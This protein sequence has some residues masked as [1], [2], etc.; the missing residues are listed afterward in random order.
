M[1]AAVKKREA[2]LHT[3][4]NILFYAYAENPQ[5]PIVMTNQAKMRR[6]QSE[7]IFYSFNKITYTVHYI[8]KATKRNAY[9]WER[10]SAI[11]QFFNLPYDAPKKRAK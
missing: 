6:G 8:S 10:L 9:Q 2:E 3:C 7:S 11:S 5:T 1:K 4:L